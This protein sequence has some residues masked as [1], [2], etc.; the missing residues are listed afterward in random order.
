[1]RQSNTKNKTLC[2]HFQRIWIEMNSYVSSFFLKSGCYG[3]FV[4]LCHNQTIPHDCFK[5]AK[6][7][8]KIIEVTKENNNSLVV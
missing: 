8:L 2:I 1:M 7:A 3:G 6:I 5:I 4:E